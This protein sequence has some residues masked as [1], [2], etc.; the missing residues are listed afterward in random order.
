MVSEHVIQM[1]AGSA[2]LR[3]GEITAAH[4]AEQKDY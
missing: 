1:H 2:C 3:L 4:D